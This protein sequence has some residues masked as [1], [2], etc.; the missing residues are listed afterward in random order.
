M[1]TELSYIICS[2]SKKVNDDVKLWRK[3]LNGASFVNELYKLTENQFGI[4]GIQ[5]A[6]A[7]MYLNV[8]VKDLISRLTY[9]YLD[10]AEIQLSPISYAWNLS[11][12]YY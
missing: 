1:Y 11:F 7:T 10:H 5:I 4:V 3:I 6:S 12:V 2:K 9:Y 8:F